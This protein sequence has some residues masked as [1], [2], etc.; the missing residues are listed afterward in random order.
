[1]SPPRRSES[2]GGPRQRTGCQSPAAGKNKEK[3]TR[4]FPSCF[5]PNFAKNP[6]RQQQPLHRPVESPASN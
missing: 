5:K 6:V 4:T 3:K 1:M 2:R